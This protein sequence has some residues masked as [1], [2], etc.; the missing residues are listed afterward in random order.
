M[1]TLERFRSLAASYGAEFARWP[2]KERGEAQT[3]LDTSA[4]ARLLFKEAQILDEAITKAS[5]RENPA[6][7]IEGRELA[8]A[9]LR[10]AVAERIS[11]P[12]RLP[13]LHSWRFAP[14]LFGILRGTNS[15]PVG[16]VGLAAGA[17][18]T[19]AMG[20]LI[21]WSWTTR[22]A[23]GDLIAFLETSSIQILTHEYQ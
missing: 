6:T 4:Q 7:D 9:L 15:M 19:I 2:E 1:L 21:G 13:Q 5:A 11:R 8:L 18:L 22:P 16:A 20:L 12:V 14:R 10:S 17:C 3:L 23:S